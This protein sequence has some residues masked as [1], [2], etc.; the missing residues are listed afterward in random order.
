MT[1][2]L[3]EHKLLDAGHAVGGH[4]KHLVARSIGSQSLA[5]LLGEQLNRIISFWE[6]YVVSL[7][8]YKLS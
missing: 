5:G 8:N 3:Q 7:Y 6:T 4:D 2:Y 1:S